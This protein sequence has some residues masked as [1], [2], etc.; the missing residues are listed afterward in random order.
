MNQNP[1]W[2]APQKTTDPLASIALAISLT[3]AIGGTTLGV[4]AWKKLFILETTLQ[5]ANLP[6]VEEGD[7]KDYLVVLFS[8]NGAIINVWEAE[9]GVN[10]TLS[11]LRFK[12]RSGNH[13]L[14]NG[15]YLCVEVPNGEWEEMRDALFTNV[16]APETDEGADEG[17]EPCSPPQNENDTR[18]D[19]SQ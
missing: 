12:S 1:P 6:L 15:E 18:S 16:T 17:D 2:I 13:W 5:N 14:I 10:K 19:P 4:L 9:G 3:L 8:D 7:N 11:G